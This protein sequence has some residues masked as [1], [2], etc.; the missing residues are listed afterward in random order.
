MSN[1]GIEYPA[2]GEMAFCDL[3][4]PPPLR[5][6]QILLRTRFS[7]ITNGTERHALLAEHGWSVFPSRHGYQHVCAVEAVGSEVE[8]FRVGDSVFFGAY[9]GHRAWH[10]VDLSRDHLCRRLPEDLDLP[11]CALFGV[12][13]VAMRGVRR[14][15]VAPAQNVWVVGLGLVGQFTAQAARAVGARV[16]A[17]DLDSSR[18]AVASSLGAHTVL[19][20]AEPGTQ[21]ALA[22][23]GPYHCI[24]D[25]AGADSLLT[26]VHRDR[27]LACRGVIGLL[28][29]RSETRFPWAMLHGGVEGSIEVSCHFSQDDLRV[30]LYFARDGVIRTGPLISHRVPVAEAPGIYRTLRDRPSELLGVVFDWSA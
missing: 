8:S 24:L 10:V 14:C 17:T 23:G 21:Q 26:Q 20:A 15:R 11:S 16:T 13:G 29:V 28:A 25:C 27:L 3:G 5:P 12:A 30:L 7:A 4:D 22:A 2:R 18:L 19:N 6:T 1:L 9:V